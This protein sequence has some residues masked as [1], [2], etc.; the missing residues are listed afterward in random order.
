MLMLLTPLVLLVNTGDGWLLSVCSFSGNDGD[1]PPFAVTSTV[2]ALIR[3]RLIGSP[4]S[5]ERWLSIRILLT[6]MLPGTVSPSAEMKT[7]GVFSSSS[8]WPSSFFR[9]SDLGRSRLPNG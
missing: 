3:V 7:D 5:I 8:F 6:P 1:E 4:T 2:G 9:T